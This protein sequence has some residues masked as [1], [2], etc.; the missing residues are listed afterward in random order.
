MTEIKFKP[1][2]GMLLLELPKV[3]E[4]TTSGVIK[5]PEMI[6]EE[7]KKIDNFLTVVALADNVNLKLE[8]SPD[9]ITVGTKVL[10]D[11]PQ[12]NLL[13]VDDVNYVSISYRAIL[14]YRL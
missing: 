6:Q 8:L 9:T 14:G 1:L 10:V 12:A 13:E 2:N 3:E 11:L 7:Q 5:S 4:T